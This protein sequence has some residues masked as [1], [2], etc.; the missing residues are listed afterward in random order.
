MRLAG[1]GDIPLDKLLR[2]LSA[3]LHIKH[4]VQYVEPITPKVSDIVLRE[5]SPRSCQGRVIYFPLP[6]GQHIEYR[7]ASM[8]IVGR[9]EARKEQKETKQSTH[10]YVPS[11]CGGGVRNSDIRSSKRGG[12]VCIRALPMSNLTGNFICR[13][14][15]MRE[16]V[17]EMQDENGRP[18]TKRSVRIERDPETIQK[19]P[20]LL[21]LSLSTR[22][23]SPRLKKEKR[24]RKKYSP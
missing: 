13:D 5:S 6:L 3:R 22:D 4:R 7:Q 16:E 18:R 12:S 24:E 1:G 11:D 17:C 14:P 19:I 21:R 9:S 20:C 8:R 10:L 23:T 2:A 15:L